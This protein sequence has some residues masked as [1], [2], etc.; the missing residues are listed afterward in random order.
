[1]DNDIIEDDWYYLGRFQ[2]QFWTLEQLLAWIATGDPKIV[3]SLSVEG[4][5][6]IP[7]REAWD[8]TRDKYLLIERA[9]GCADLDE[10][11]I[12]RIKLSS[13]H[14][15]VIQELRSGRLVL[16]WKL[17][18]KMREEIARFHWV[19]HDFERNVRGFLDVEGGNRNEDS[20]VRVERDQVLKIWPEVSSE[21]GP[22]VKDVTQA[23]RLLTKL[24]K[25]SQEKPTMTREEALDWVRAQVPSLGVRAGKDAWKEAM[26]QAR[27]PAWG[28]SGRRPSDN[29]NGTPT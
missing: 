3:G 21:Q 26:V 17:C 1:M 19:D 6:G 27:A 25:E 16:T 11:A 23:T 24:M 4:L 12:I 28:K 29:R 9:I 18:G 10:K 2:D 5:E 20:L 15:A 14:N 13:A 8:K 7:Y 22:T